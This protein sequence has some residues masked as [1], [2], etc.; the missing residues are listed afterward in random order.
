MKDFQDK[1][2]T[3]AECGE[4]FTWTA[5]GQAFFA[6]KGFTE[7][8]RCKGCR[9]ARK[10]RQPGGMRAIRTPEGFTTRRR[11][12]RTLSSSIRLCLPLATTR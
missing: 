11:V 7:P 1:Q 9:E 12:C 5:K 3:C 8:K 4:K 6:E 10:E 2:L